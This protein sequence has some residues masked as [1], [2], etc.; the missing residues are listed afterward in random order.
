M[1]P[2][3]QLQRRVVSNSQALHPRLGPAGL[4][5]YSPITRASRTAWETCPP[6]LARFS[7]ASARPSL[8]NPGS[9]LYQR[10]GATP[11][12]MSALHL[13]LP[14]PRLG[15][16]RRRAS[17]NRASRQDPEHDPRTLDAAAAPHISVK[18]NAFQL[19]IQHDGARPT[20]LRGS[21][22]SGRSPTP[23]HSP[24]SRT[25]SAPGRGST[26]ALGLGAPADVLTTTVRTGFR[27]IELAQL[28]YTSADVARR[29]ISPGDQWHFE[30]NGKA[31][32]SLGTNIIPFDP[33]CAR[34][35]TEQ[36]RWVLESVVASGQNM[37]RARVHPFAPRGE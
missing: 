24:G 6:R 36:V 12:S 3:G 30:V 16:I 35:T 5:I 17:P 23:S 7:D 4:K 25:T 14:R 2:K 11:A 26:I 8:V 20:R 29:G 15:P 1:N 19:H 21:P 13:P 18:R 27:T 31:F 32:Y 22:S 34:T 9:L 37:V 28:P 33:F 10:T